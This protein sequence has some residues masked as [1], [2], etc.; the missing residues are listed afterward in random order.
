MAPDFERFALTPWPIACWASSGTRLLSSALA[1]SCSRWADR[2]RE[3]I[4][5]Y[6]A[7]AFDGVI[8]TMRTASIRGFGGSTP[9]RAGDSP[10]WTQRQNF[11]SA[12]TMRCW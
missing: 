6:S 2:V 10:L 4:A 9:K 11:R 8:S 7:Q 1:C 3:K 5:A 12:V